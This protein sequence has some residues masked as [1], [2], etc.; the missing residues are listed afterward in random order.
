VSIKLIERQLTD[1]RNGVMELEAQVRANPRNAWKKIIGISK[2]QPLD[3]EAARLGAEWR[4]REN[5]RK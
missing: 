4:A 3:R 5:K 2:E 1:L